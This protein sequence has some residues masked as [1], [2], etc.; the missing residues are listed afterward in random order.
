VYPLGQCED[1]GVFALCP[2]L[3]PRP[4]NLA[5]SFLAFL[6]KS[7]LRLNQLPMLSDASAAGVSGYLCG[8][9]WTYMW[10]WVILCRLT[11]RE[12][13]RQHDVQGRNADREIF[14]IF[15][16][17][18]SEHVH[19]GQA[20]GDPLGQLAWTMAFSRCTQFCAHHRTLLSVTECLAITGRPCW[21]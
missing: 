6:S 9:V 21:V 10:T 17:H 15:F 13:I 8:S 16:L 20:G 5:E 1:N 7:S 12:A 14:K 19:K 18:A 3:C 2:V 4:P 11:G